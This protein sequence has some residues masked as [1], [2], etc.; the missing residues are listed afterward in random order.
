MIQGKENECEKA[1][2]EAV[3]VLG[4]ENLTRRVL[5]KIKKTFELSGKEFKYTIP[6][7]VSFFICENKLIVVVS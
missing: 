7:P 3:K 4:I 1:L 6:P 5:F 2:E